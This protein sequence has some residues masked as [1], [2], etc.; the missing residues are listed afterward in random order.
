MMIVKQLGVYKGSIPCPIFL[1]YSVVIHLQF[2]WILS[3]ARHIPDRGQDIFSFMNQ[4]SEKYDNSQK[5]GQG[6][7]FDHK[8]R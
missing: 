8:R 3:I 1:K 5:V 7:Y 2:M 6:H 4:M